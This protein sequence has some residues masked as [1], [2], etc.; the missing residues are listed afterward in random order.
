M[1]LAQLFSQFCKVKKTSVA[2]VL[3]ALPML[4]IATIGD[5]KI[6]KVLLSPCTKSLHHS[7]N[8]QQFSNS[9]VYYKSTCLCVNLIPTVVKEY[10]LKKYCAK[11]AT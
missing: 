7:I 10:Q 8:K 5:S 11:N 2:K 4:H 3:R 6:C 1:V 9:V